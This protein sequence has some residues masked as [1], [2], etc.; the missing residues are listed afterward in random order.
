[1]VRR[2]WEHVQVRG[3]GEFLWEFEHGYKQGARE[4]KESWNRTR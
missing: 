1:M 4:A 2:R 3:G